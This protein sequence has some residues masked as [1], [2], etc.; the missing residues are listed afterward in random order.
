[1]SRGSPGATPPSSVSTQRAANT[2]A[3]WSDTAQTFAS[4]K[5]SGLIHRALAIARSA[6]LAPADS[7]EVTPGGSIPNVELGGRNVHSLTD[8]LQWQPPQ[9]PSNGIRWRKTRQSPAGLLPAAGLGDRPPFAIRFC[10]PI[11]D[12]GNLIILGFLEGAALGNLH[13]NQRL[14]FHHFLHRSHPIMLIE[15]RGDMA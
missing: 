14:T 1:M 12:G 6:N 8:L 3:A 10:P 4:V 15:G 11:M 9:D 2:K 7:E 13:F 5:N